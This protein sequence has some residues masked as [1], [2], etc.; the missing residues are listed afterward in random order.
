MGEAGAVWNMT[1]ETSDKE[2]RAATIEHPNISARKVYANLGQRMGAKD[3]SHAL[4]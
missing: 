4:T 3:T 2:F 1:G